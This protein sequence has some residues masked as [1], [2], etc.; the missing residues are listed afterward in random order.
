V[1]GKKSHKVDNKKVNNSHGW[2]CGIPTQKLCL[3]KK[4]NKENGIGYSSGKKSQSIN[5]KNEG[6]EKM[7]ERKYIQKCKIVEKV[8]EDSGYLL[9]VYINV[10]ELVEMA[11]SEGWVNLT[12]AKRMEPSDKGAT[13]YAYEN[14]FKPQKQAGYKPKTNDPF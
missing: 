3:I 1:A 14:D 7:P 8:F 10:D 13:H 12:I 11:D 6:N 5:Q 2:R 9:N 4:Q